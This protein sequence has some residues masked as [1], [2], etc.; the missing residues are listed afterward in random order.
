MFVP[1]SR[2]CSSYECLGSGRTALWRHPGWTDST[3]RY[4]GL[5]RPGGAVVD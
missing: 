2:A 4:D 3:Y 1:S 5:W